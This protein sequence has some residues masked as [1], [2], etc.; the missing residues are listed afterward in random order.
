MS[1]NSA[2]KASTSLPR[3]VLLLG[4]VS[5]F[6]DFSSEIY[7]AVLPY[8]ILSIGGT[9]LAI[10]II[11]GVSDGFL[12]FL[13]AYFGFISDKLAKGRKK[14]LY[15]GYGLPAIFKF[16]M[17]FVKT[18]PVLALIRAFERV[19]KG[20]RSAPRDAMIVE[21]IEGNTE[22]VGRAFGFHRSMDSF[23]AVIGSVSALLLIYLGLNYPNIIIISAFIA[24]FTLIPISLVKDS[25]RGEE[26]KEMQSN[27]AFKDFLGQGAS[28]E[29]WRLI[30]IGVFHG[31]SLISYMFFVLNTENYDVSPISWLDKAS[32]VER[33]IIFYVFFN[34]IYTLVS[35]YAGF[36]ADKTS[37][38]FS[39]KIGFAI[40]FMSLLFFLL[41]S[42]IYLLIIAFFLYGLAYG[43]NEGN[44]RAIISDKME[45]KYKATA[46]GIFHGLIGLAL[47]IGNITAGLLYTEDPLF[48]FSFA[49]IFSL[50]ALSLVFK[51]K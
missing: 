6:A 40:Y 23:G 21:S 31:L 37:K 1:R 9:S 10:G 3:N 30:I 51:Q 17:A 18:W 38:I 48:A 19:G 20:I 45:K 7:F 32:L 25:G 50:I 4:L 49:A 24:L 28:P 22:I 2:N 41:S 27:I 5:F 12:S 29:F 39:L 33:G 16:M 47:F 15:W 42:D 8:F 26:A 44:L 14:F 11:A 13:K 35:Y 46:Y 34:V 43:F 36:L